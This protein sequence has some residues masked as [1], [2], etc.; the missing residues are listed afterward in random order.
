M[1]YEEH[2]QPHLPIA[3]EQHM[4]GEPRVGSIDV[5]LVKA[6]DAAKR[7]LVAEINGIGQSAASIFELVAPEGFQLER[8]DRHQSDR[9]R[10]AERLFD[11]SLA[12]FEFGDQPGKGLQVQCL[13]LGD[14]IP[15]ALQ[16]AS[17]LW[18]RRSAVGCLSHTVIH[19]LRVS[20]AH[21]VVRIAAPC[22][23][24]QSEKHFWLRRSA[25]PPMKGKRDISASVPPCG[26]CQPNGPSVDTLGSGMSNTRPCDAFLAPRI[27]KR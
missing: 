27:S 10:E 3:F 11:L 6:Q 5:E 15:D 26:H 24:E 8:T 12:C 9:S 7:G 18:L 2:R 17:P 23:Y 13:Q 19:G 22:Y 25:F 21:R 1:A 16:E 14:E 4:G 20:F